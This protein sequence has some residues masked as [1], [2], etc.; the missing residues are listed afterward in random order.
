MIKTASSGSGRTGDYS[1]A[2][3]VSSLVDGGKS[4]IAIGN[5]AYAIDTTQATVVGTGIWFRHYRK[6]S[7]DKIVITD[8]SQGTKT[9]TKDDDGEYAVESTKI[10]QTH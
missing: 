3:G 5:N 2:L 7:G 6:N 1:V 9:I 4:A 10:Q 8:G